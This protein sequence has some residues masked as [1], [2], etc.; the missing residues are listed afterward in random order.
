MRLLGK[1]CNSHKERNVS[2]GDTSKNFAN[3]VRGINWETIYCRYKIMKY[4]QMREEKTPLG[5]VCLR[6]CVGS[7]LFCRL[8][9]TESE[10]Q[11]AIMMIGA[12]SMRSGKVNSRPAVHSPLEYNWQ[13]ISRPI[14]LLGATKKGI[15]RR[16]KSFTPKLAWRLW[17]QKWSESCSYSNFY[18]L[19]K[20][21]L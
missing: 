16:G 15:T 11:C 20:L 21:N 1:K 7:A 10:V 14:F 18:R 13:R 9:E 6:R 8:L 5:R 4:V 19:I 12:R 17:D 2:H 3:A